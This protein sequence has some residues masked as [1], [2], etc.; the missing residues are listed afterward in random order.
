MSGDQ[1]DVIKGE[2]LFTKFIIHRLASLYES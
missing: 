2:T 1:E